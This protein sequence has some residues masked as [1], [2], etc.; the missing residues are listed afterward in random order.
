MGV[1]PSRGPTS[2]VSRRGRVTARRSFSDPKGEGDSTGVTVGP[3]VS[4]SLLYG[5]SSRL[6]GCP[7]AVHGH[8]L[9]SSA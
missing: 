2:P 3:A 1:Y 7:S 4:R 6:G 9:T 8:C 5:Y